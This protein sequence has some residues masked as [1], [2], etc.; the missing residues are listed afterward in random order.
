MIK[1]A[2]EMNLAET[3]FLWKKDSDDVELYHLR[4]FTPLKEVNLCGHATLATIF[5]LFKLNQLALNQVVAFDTRS[6][7][8]FGKVVYDDDTK[9]EL[10]EMDF[11]QLTPKN[12]SIDSSEWNEILGIEKSIIID[13]A[14]TGDDLM[15]VIDNAEELIHLNPNLNLMMKHNYRCIIVTCDNKSG[16]IEDVDFISRVFA[17]RFGINEDPVTGSAHCGLAPYWCSHFKKNRLTGYQASKRGGYV[18][19]Q[20]EENNRVKLFGE[21]VLIFEINMKL[22][23]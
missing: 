9:K 4:W 19:V 15:I 1:V 6:G 20:L 14:E 8:L 5:L 23:K 18:T 7:R 21:A 17:P 22:S 13:V 12:I 10:I 2:N 3:A 11:P 16:I